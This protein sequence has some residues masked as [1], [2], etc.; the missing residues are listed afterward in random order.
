MLNIAAFGSGKGSNFQAILSA[1]QRG[2]IPGAQICLVVSNNSRAGILDIA[3]KNSLPALHVSQMQFPTDEAFVGALLSALRS[4]GANFIVLAG[5]MKMLPPQVIRAYRDRIVNIHPALLPKFGGT[6]MYG[7]HVH[8]AVLSARE[9]RSG[10]T[11]H[12]VD[13]QYDH[14]AIV[15]QKSVPVLPGDTPE[16]LAE[17]VLAVEHEIYPEALRRIASAES[18]TRK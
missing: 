6:G 4:H 13:E 1:V 14:G 2:K 16:S 12:W 7:M 15:L 18:A 8:E 3:R 5:Y 17:R 9:E 10:A 11:V